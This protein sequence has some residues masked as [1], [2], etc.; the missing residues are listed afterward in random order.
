[1]S[2]LDDELK[3]AFRRVEAPDGFTGRVLARLEQEA[4]RPP[5][6][7]DLFA[8]CRWPLPRFALAGA[9]C[10]VIGVGMHLGARRVEQVRIE[11]V[12]G[13]AVREQLLTALHITGA[14]L[15][16]VGARVRSSAE[17]D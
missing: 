4:E 3:K 6:R 16:E 5:E 11:R 14:K 13:E 2:H 10:L 9:F 7:R 17:S 1:M 8:W 12:Q 15:H